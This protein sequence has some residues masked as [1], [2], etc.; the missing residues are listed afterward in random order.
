MPF[1]GCGHKETSRRVYKKYNIISMLTEI[2]LHYETSKPIALYTPL[3]GH[4]FHY[5]VS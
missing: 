4:F 3:F 2:L 1:L 5:L